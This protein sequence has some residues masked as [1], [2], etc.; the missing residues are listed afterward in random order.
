MEP[1]LTGVAANLSSEARKSIFQEVKRH[2]RYVMIYKKN[3]DKFEEKLEMLIAKRT[4]VQQEVDA[5][6]RNVQKIKADVEEWCNRVDGK[7]DE[8]KKKVKDLQDRAINKCFIGLC[9]SIKSRYQL[10]KRSEEGATTFQELITEGGQLTTP[11]GHWDVP[12]DIEDEPPKDF[13]AFES[14]QKVFNDTME[15]VKDN[16]SISMIGVYGMGGV[17]KSTL[18]KEVVRQAKKAKLFDWVVLC[19]VNQTPDIR[20]IQNQI[21]DS[22]GLRFEEQSI[23]GR[24]CRLR[25]RFKEEKKF[26]LVLDDLWSKL[27]F[28][29]VGIPSGDELKRCK[30]LLASRSQNVLLQFDGMHARNTFP[31]GLL[32]HKESWDL[33]KKMAGEDIQISSSSE[34]QIVGNEIAKRC[35]GL[36]IA[37][38]AIARTL[39]NKDPSA[40]RDASRQL[41]QR[42]SSRGLKEIS[43]AVYSAIKL[44]YNHIDGEKLK[45]FFLFCNLLSH[46]TLIQDLL[47]YTIGLGLL[48]GGYTMEE[49]RDT[50]LTWVSK[51][52]ASGLLL[53]S[54][55]NERFDM[56][57]I[58]CNVALSIAYT[59]NSCVLTLKQE[60]VLKD[61]PTET[62]KQHSWINLRVDGNTVLPDQVECPQLTFL[63]ISSED[64]STKVPPE[65]F[66]EMKRLKV[67]DLTDMDLSSFPSS[68]GLLSSLQTLCL[69]ESNLGDITVVGELKALEVLSLWNTDIEKLSMEIAQLVKLRLLD[70][71]GCTKLKDAKA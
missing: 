65:F 27:D 29:E 50:L 70:L 49:A 55:N 67:L 19:V 68:I 58:I 7:I 51:L 6:K 57:D 54:Y 34:L 35:G 1:I 48:P 43:P 23:P 9:P 42:S 32:N 44:S 71:R 14:R 63:H 37:I 10:S 64:C 39:R 8:E 36:P 52:K 3:V 33:F 53:D 22:L 11:V 30:I 16:T 62:M 46:D 17:G 5:A 38:S 45:Q 47:K 15:A 25:E 31:I 26:L 13:E 28:T 56:H 41:L 2:I 20:E 61:W 66:K 21:A 40:W 12:Q 24:A 60:D 69:D 59:K 4:S 18:L